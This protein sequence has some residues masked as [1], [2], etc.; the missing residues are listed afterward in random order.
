VAA[1]P[2]DSEA[3]LPV[4]D[5]RSPSAAPVIL[6]SENEKQINR[7]LSHVQ[8]ADRLAEHGVGISPSMLLFGPPGCGKT[9]IAK[10]I[11]SSLGLPLITARA[12]ALDQW[13]ECRSRVW[14]ALSSLFKEAGDFMDD[15]VVRR[16]DVCHR[17]SWSTGT[18]SRQAIS[19][20]LVLA[21]LRF[22]RHFPAH[23][24][25]C[26]IEMNILPAGLSLWGGHIFQFPCVGQ[27]LIELAD[28][29][30]WQICHQLRQV[31]L[32][33]DTV[34]TSLSPEQA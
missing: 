11:A 15:L 28:R 12:D 22:A 30:C 6:E 4:A 21:R 20:H 32:R 26:N 27:S 25:E 13:K 33:V 14:L 5:E 17:L 10:H 1:I 2:V 24:V 8:A 31:T 23:L 29:H 18:Q 34:T 7:F 19:T 3:R 9:Q 16:D